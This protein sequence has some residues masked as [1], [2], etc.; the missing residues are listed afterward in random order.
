MEQNTQESTTEISQEQKLEESIKI[1]TV[2]Q[3]ALDNMVRLDLRNY[4]NMLTSSGV[5]GNK[6]LQIIQSLERAIMAGLDYGVGVSN[7][8]ILDKGP[9]AKLEASMAAHVARIRENSMLL[10]ANNLKNNE[11]TEQKQGE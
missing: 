10:I 11:E 7:Q 3:K 5:S 8:G 1:A 6:K 9:L 4:L 2:H